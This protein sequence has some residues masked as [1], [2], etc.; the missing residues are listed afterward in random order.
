MESR[1]R[2]GCRWMGQ[3]GDCHIDQLKWRSFFCI[4]EKFFSSSSLDLAT[5]YAYLQPD[6]RL[7]GLFENSFRPWSA[8]RLSLVILL[9]RL[10]TQGLCGGGL[11][12]W[13]T[14]RSK[15]ETSSSIRTRYLSPKPRYPPIDEA[16]QNKPRKKR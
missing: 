12:T 14:C 1:F 11:S 15:G 10:V 2:F 4:S 8:S 6:G 9:R 3:C 13:S 7:Y 16:T 5:F